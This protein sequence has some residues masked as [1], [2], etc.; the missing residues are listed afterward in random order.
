MSA[1]ITPT[2]VKNIIKYLSLATPLL[3]ELCDA[4]G[5]SFLKVISAITLS[6]SAEAEVNL[7]FPSTF[8]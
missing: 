2:R 1:H 8:L 7:N 4:F 3:D 5:S 6:L